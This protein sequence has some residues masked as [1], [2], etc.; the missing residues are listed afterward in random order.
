MYGKFQSYLSE[1]LNKIA[2]AGLY[3]KERCI[4]SEQG[5]EITLADGSKALNL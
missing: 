1:E 5:A 4:C 3:K 2:Q